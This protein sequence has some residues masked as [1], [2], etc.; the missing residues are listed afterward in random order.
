V[1]RQSRKLGIACGIY[2]ALVALASV[3]LGWHYAIDAYAG[4]GAALL[5]WYGVGLA[6]R[7]IPR[8]V[9]VP[10]EGRRQLGAG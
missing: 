2:A 9:N 3:H 10:A 1:V 7:R 4:A 5:I 8:A 6:L